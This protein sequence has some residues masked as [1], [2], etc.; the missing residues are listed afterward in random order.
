MFSQQ[1]AGSVCYVYKF[2]YAIT[3]KWQIVLVIEKKYVL[4]RS[5]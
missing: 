2:Q 4:S 3:G 5:R 1:I